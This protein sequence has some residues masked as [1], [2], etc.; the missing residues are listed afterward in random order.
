MRARSAS[1]SVDSPS[2]VEPTRSQ[3]RIVTTLRCSRAGSAAA[4]AVPHA[5]QK[6]ASSAFSRPQLGQSGTRGVYEG[7]RPEARRARRATAR[8]RRRCPSARGTRSRARRRARPRRCGRR[9]R[10]PRRAR[11]GRSPS[12]PGSRSA[13]RARPPRRAAS[14]PRRVAPRY[15]RTRARAALHLGCAVEI[16]HCRDRADSSRRTRAPRRAAPGGTGRRARTASTVERTPTSPIATSTSCPR[17][18]SNS[19]RSRSRPMSSRPR[20]P[21]RRGPCAS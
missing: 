11:R 17:R 20:C 21:P 9:A 4:S 16:V 18:S 6:R 19:A 12:A 13:R 1:G 15:E 8:P 3:K 5:L 10:A 7:R 14:A 2:A